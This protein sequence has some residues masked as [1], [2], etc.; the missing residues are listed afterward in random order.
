MLS[1]IIS[2]RL[3]AALDDPFEADPA[4]FLTAAVAIGSSAEIESARQ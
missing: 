2:P 4:S 1:L 3:P